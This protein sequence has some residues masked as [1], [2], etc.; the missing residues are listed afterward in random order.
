MQLLDESLPSAINIV[1]TT[2]LF[3]FMNYNGE[4]VNLVAIFLIKFQ[5]NFTFIII[6]LTLQQT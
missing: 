3:K 4:F 2:I 5:L 1:C 6:E